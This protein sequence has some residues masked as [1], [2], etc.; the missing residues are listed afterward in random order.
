[1]FAVIRFYKEK[2]ETKYVFD[3]VW[4]FLR[5]IT[6]LREGYTNNPMFLKLALSIVYDMIMDLGYR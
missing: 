4:P 1:M 5:S 3:K 6:D 2:P